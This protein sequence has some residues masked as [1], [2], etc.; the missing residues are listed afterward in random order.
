MSVVDPCVSVCL[1][2]IPSI[3]WGSVMDND[4]MGLKYLSE[5]VFPPA[6]H[7]TCWRQLL[8]RQLH[9]ATFVL[10]SCMV[11]PVTS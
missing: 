8:Q 7:D 5:L 9:S 6:P 3:G 11:A 2:D 4:V 1:L 10:V